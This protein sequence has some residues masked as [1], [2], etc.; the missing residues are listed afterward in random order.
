[1]FMVVPVSMVVPIFMV[2]TIFLFGM[3]FGGGG[4][5]PYGKFLLLVMISAFVFMAVFLPFVDVGF[6]A[7]FVSVIF[8]VFTGIAS[9]SEY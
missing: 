1:M 3:I 2:V 7:V 9:E 6:G 4:I 8:L 5:F